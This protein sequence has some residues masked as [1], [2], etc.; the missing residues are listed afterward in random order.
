MA[1]C[2]QKRE[3][4]AWSAGAQ[5]DSEP[6]QIPRGLGQS[7]S[8]RGHAHAADDD[9]A[10]DGAPQSAREQRAC[11]ATGHL[12]DKHHAVSTLLEQ[13]AMGSTTRDHA[14]RASPDEDAVALRGTSWLGAV[15]IGASI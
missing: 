11:R 1:R 4:R 5:L 8:S 2:D 13:H 6:D 12:T 3:C 10:H 14:V 9:D 7:V 15:E